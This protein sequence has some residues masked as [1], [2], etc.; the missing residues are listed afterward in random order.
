MNKYPGQ[1]DLQ[2]LLHLVNQELDFLGPFDL[3]GDNEMLKF[4]GALV[5][6]QEHLTKETTGQTL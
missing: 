2:L 1:P 5:V 6:I 3:S 4:A